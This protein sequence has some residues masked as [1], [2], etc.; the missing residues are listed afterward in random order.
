M[1]DMSFTP[2]NS[3]SATSVRGKILTGVFKSGSGKPKR[4]SAFSKFFETG[5]E[6]LHVGINVPHSVFI[7]QMKK[8]YP[9]ILVL[10]CQGNVDGIKEL[11]ETIK[12]E[13]MRSM[14]RII[15]YGPKVSESVRDEVHA[16]ACAG[17]EQDLF[18]MVNE[19]VR[20]IIL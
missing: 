12:K 6:V 20:E 19:M 17:N 18:D 14:A 10:V 8:F 13:G 15:L 11:I 9:H 16:D 4:C 7:Q 1:E 3:N 2:S 5:F